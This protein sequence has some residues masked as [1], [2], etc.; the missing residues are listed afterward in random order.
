MLRGLFIS[1]TSLLNSLVL[2]LEVFGASYSWSVLLL[3]NIVFTVHI[4]NL[5]ILTVTLLHAE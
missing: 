2:A 3:R 1:G 5:L 4:I